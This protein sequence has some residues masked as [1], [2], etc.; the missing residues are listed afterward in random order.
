MI[1]AANLEINFEINDFD[2]PNKS[3]VFG[4][5]RSLMDISAYNVP[6]DCEVWIR[7]SGYPTT[8][9]V[10]EINAFLRNS[11]WAFHNVV[12][13]GGG[14]TLDL[15]KAISSSISENREMGRLLM[16]P[17]NIGSGT[18]ITSFATIW[19]FSSGQKLSKS[20]P[21]NINRSIFYNFGYFLD[22][23]RS[24]ALIGALDA[25]AHAYDSFY[26]VLADSRTRQMAREAIVELNYL[27]S[28]GFESWPNELLISRFHNATILAAFCI[29]KTKTSLSHGLSYG[30]TLHL[31][32]PHGIAVGLILREYLTALAASLTKD[33]SEA[34][35]EDSLRN[36]D[37]VLTKVSRE[38]YSKIAIDKIENSIDWG[39]VNNFLPMVTK[40]NCFTLLGSVINRISQD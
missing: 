20:V 11:N 35:L 5:A 4:T 22:V 9:E 31:G 8:E 15:S 6:T 34:I 24:D 30:L 40:E 39:R 14:S 28:S 2:I 21:D 23:D 19:D 10:S 16:I 13:I 7:K 38:K 26:S 37:S 18:E 36:L 33:M 27:L 3:I 32:I 29:N 1:M 12:G 25:L 17:T